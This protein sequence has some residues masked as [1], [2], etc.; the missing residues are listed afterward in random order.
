MFDQDLRTI[1]YE[2]KVYSSVAIKL[3]TSVTDFYTC[4]DNMTPGKK[5]TVTRNTTRMLKR[6]LLD[7][8]TNLHKKYL[9]EN[10]GSKMFHFV[11]QVQTL[12]GC[13]NRV[14]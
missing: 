13:E 12:L 6:L 7:S 2:K 9:R 3:K 5:E 8:M 1:S 4:D 11:L 10:S 14:D